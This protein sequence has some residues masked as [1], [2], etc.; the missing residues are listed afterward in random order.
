MDSLEA[1][2]RVKSLLALYHAAEGKQYFGE[3]VT[4]IQHAVQAHLY[5][6]HSGADDELSIAALLH[7]VGHLLEWENLKRHAD[8]GVIDHDH[9]GAEY[10]AHLGF[11]PRVCALVGGHV[12]AKRYLVAT[13]EAYAARLSP[14]S[15]ITLE[16]QGGPM[17]DAE[18]ARFS[19][20]EYF[21]D[22]LR[23]RSWD[24]Q[25]KDPDAAVPPLESFEPLL[26][27]HL[28]RTAT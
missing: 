7:D 27:A 12:N 20:S 16:L 11:S 22:C 6:K 9:A 13:N 15:I 18:S 14:A 4:Q 17:T 8:V 24:E 19:N 3:A 10:L 2:Q 23:L 28:L 26:V 1:Q 5:A 25:A 21:R